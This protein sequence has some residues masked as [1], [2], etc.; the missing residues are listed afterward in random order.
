MG[1]NVGK[2]FTLLLMA[3]AVFAKASYGNESGSTSRTRSLKRDIVAINKILAQNKIEKN[4]I[5]AEVTE[6]EFRVAAAKR[7]IQIIEG[8]EKVSSYEL[9][10]LQNQLSTI[11]Q[12]H[13]MALSQYQII[14]VEEYKHRDYRKKLYFL[15]TSSNF[16][17]L[18]NRLNYLEKLK[19]FRKRQLKAIENKKKEI[20]DKLRV[21]SGSSQEK[22]KISKLKMEEI[23]RLNQ[24]LN[25]KYVVLQRLQATNNDLQLQLNAAQANISSFSKKKELENTSGVKDASTKIAKLIWP[26]KRGL[27]VG[28]FGV[29]K[30]SKER[31]VQVENNG[32]DILVIDNEPVRCV[33]DGEIKA[34]LQIPGSNTTLIIDHKTYYSVY[35]NLGDTKLNVGD[36]VNKEDFL[37][38]VAKDNQGAFKLHFEIWQGTKKLNPE[39]YLLGKLN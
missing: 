8:A 11:E 14:L 24:L 35:S 36:K 12:E 25:E 20:S 32:I 19:E 5:D 13:K 21:Y 9:E 28:R 6:A 39:D 38:K 22:T 15:A 18:I 26:L 16:S 2:Y 27:V 37:G 4:T 30:H 29:H 7:V 1:I 10:R 3:L 31:K 33:A 23:N 17:E 34:V